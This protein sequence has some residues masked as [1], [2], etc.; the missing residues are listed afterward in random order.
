MKRLALLSASILWA[1]AFAPGASATPVPAPGPSVL[2]AG[3]GTLV[4]NGVFFPG[5]ATCTNDGCTGAPPL[6]IQKGTDLEFVNLDVGFVANSHRVVSVKTK[7]GRPLFASD[8][9]SGPGQD[10]IITSHLKPAVY[11]FVCSTH[12][13]MFGQLEVVK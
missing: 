12:F 7:R 9:V 5:T 13:G 4:T 1:A 6:Q 3:G 8:D 2:F 10:T 11:T